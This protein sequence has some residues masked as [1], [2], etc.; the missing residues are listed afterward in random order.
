[1][2]SVY[3]GAS[4]HILNDRC[5]CSELLSLSV[6]TFKLFYIL[7]MEG[8]DFNRVVAV[9]LFIWHFYT[10]F[11]VNSI[12]KSAVWCPCV[13]QYL[14]ANIHV[15]HVLC[16]AEAPIVFMYHHLCCIQSSS[17]HVFKYNEVEQG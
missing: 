8:S 14:T 4:R 7:L 9:H 5:S 12:V 17:V 2:Y 16:W 6:M 15:L 11:Q 10:R 13:S 3:L 1:M